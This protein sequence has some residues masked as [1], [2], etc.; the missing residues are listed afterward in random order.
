MEKFRAPAPAPGKTR[1]WSAPGPWIEALISLSGWARPGR[2]FYLYFG[3]GCAEIAAM[4]AR[5][6]LKNPVHAKPF[7]WHKQ[8]TI[9]KCFEG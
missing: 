7:S 4:R 2:K 1:L 8:R 3:S 9:Q 5:P 6:G